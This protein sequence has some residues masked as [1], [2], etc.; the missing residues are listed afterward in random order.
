MHIDSHRRVPLDPN[1]LKRDQATGQVIGPSSGV[2]VPKPGED[3]LSVYGDAE[4]RAHGCGPQ[5]VAAAGRKPS[6][7]AGLPMGAVESMD[8]FTSSDPTDEDRIGPAHRLIQ[9]WDKLG[10][11]ATRKVARTLAA[12]SLCTHPPGDWSHVEL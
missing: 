9:G 8:L 7:V 12:A 1:M 5:E 2:F 6:V 4:L 11:S 3:G 10:S